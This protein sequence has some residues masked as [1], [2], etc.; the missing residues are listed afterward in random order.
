MYPRPS[1]RTLRK[2][3]Y[4]KPSFISIKYRKCA[5]HQLSW[6]ME[7]IWQCFPRIIR[8]DLIVGP[9]LQFDWLDGS[10]VLL[11]NERCMYTNSAAFRGSLGF[12]FRIN[13]QKLSIGF[14]KLLMIV[15]IYTPNDVHLS[16]IVFH[17]SGLLNYFKFK[18]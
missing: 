3:L 16:Q 7:T 12:R 11:Q 17:Q 14:S 4:T 18:L 5:Y 13:E 9:Y 2:S 1:N 6:R 15:I 10:I 8:S